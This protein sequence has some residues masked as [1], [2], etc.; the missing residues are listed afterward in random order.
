MLPLKA[1]APAAAPE[2]LIVGLESW[3]T[4]WPDAD[5]LARRHWDEVDGGVEPRRVY[6]PDAAKMRALQTL[7]IMQIVTARQA[8]RLVAYATWNITPDIE[9]MRLLIAQQGAWYAAPDAPRGAGYRV[10][11]YSVAWLRSL[12][13]HMIY[14]HHRTQGR[15]AD[16]GPFFRRWG[17]KHI[18]N[19]YSLWIGGESPPQ[20]G[21]HA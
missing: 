5:A 19:T 10:F 1:E 6:A 20:G 2:R 15:G 9:S 8:G 17:A 14:P 4:F 13:V 7:G 12:G 18:Q 11:E 16:L 3:D 21:S